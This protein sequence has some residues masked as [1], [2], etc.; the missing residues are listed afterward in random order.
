VGRWLLSRVLGSVPGDH[1]RLVVNKVAMEEVFFRAVGFP[2]QSSLSSV[3][4]YHL[5]LKRATALTRQHIITSSV[6]KVTA[7][8]NFASV[9]S[10]QFVLNSVNTVITYS[11]IT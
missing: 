4:I 3:L 9:V 2:C 1:A 6:L 11:Y 8:E 10:G 7:K 5:S